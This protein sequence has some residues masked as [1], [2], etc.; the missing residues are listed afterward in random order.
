MS[1]RSFPPRRDDILLRPLPVNV[2][3]ETAQTLLDQESEMTLIATPANENSC[4]IFG[5][6]KPN[7]EPTQLR[8]CNHRLNALRRSL[9][10]RTGL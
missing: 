5:Y 4:V 9:E 7:G 1:Q 3:A 2:R 6:A 8:H 10:E